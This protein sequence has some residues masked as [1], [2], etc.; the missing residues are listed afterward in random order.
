[1]SAFGVAQR[2]K[3]D[4]QG[5]K[6]ASQIGMIECNSARSEMDTLLSFRKQFIVE[7]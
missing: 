1:M 6:K 4:V 2:V 5:S 3:K 7:N